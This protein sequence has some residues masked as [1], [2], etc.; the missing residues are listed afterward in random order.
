MR[1]VGVLQSVYVGTPRQYGR[2]DATNPRERLWKT[3]FFR[4]PVTQPRWLFTTHLEGNKQ[5]D[6]KNHGQ[7]NQA[8]LVYAAGHYP[9][10]QRELN[11]PDIGPGG[12]GEN[13]TVSG[14]GEENVCIGDIYAIGEAHICVTEPRYPCWKIERRWDI[15]G[16]TDLVA[17]TGRTGWYCS[18]VQ[19]GMVEPSLPI[20]LV[21][22]VYPE[23]TMALIN[24][25]VH[26]HNDDVA[27]AQALARC[28]LLD[29]W[30]PQLILRRAMGPNKKERGS[31]RSHEEH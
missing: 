16:L 4:H 13:F 29:A 21:E 22:R 30:W 1:Q 27:R 14:L 10:W 23:W 17:Q 6:T 26:A 28:P 20:M 12:F 24:D 19:E 7:R 5:A 3:S 2:A 18:V 25:F 11:R 8:V 9:I 31:A 15:A